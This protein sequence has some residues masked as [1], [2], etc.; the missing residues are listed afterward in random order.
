MKSGHGFQ[1]GSAS[2]L[3]LAISLASQASVAATE[4]DTAKSVAFEEV[5]VTA[6]RRT[7]RSLDVPITITALSAEQ[8]GRGDVLKLGD[9]GKLTPGLRFDDLG[10]NS[11]PTIRGVGTAV[12]V[13]GA[14][15]N[16][17]IY[18]DGF[19]SPNM[20][21]ADT[22]LLNVE[23]IQV[24]KGPQGTLFGRNSTGGAILVTTSDPSSEEEFRVRASYGSYNAER[25]EI[26]GTGGGD[27]R[28]AVDLA[29]MYRK[30]DG[31][32]ENIYTGDD[33]VGAYE[34]WMVRTGF[35]L[36][37]SDKT[38]IIL[39]H[40]QTRID[41]P[42]PVMMGFY[43]KD[44][45][46]LASAPRIA[47]E[48]FFQSVDVASE[49][50]DV[51]YGFEPSYTATSKVTQLT[52]KSDLDFANFTSY[53]QYRSESGSHAYDFDT[54]TLPILHYTFTTTDEI[55]SQEFLLS[56]TN[57]SKLQWT[58][59]LFYFS[60]ETLY[61]RN[62]AS[63]YG[64]PFAISEGSGVKASSVAVFGD[65]TYAIMDNL[66]WTIGARYSKDKSTDAY[67]YLD[68]PYRTARTKIPLDDLDDS[69]ITPRTALRFE[70]N[71][72]SSIYISYSE[73]IKSS[74]INVAAGS[75]VDTQ[76][77]L[78]VDAEEIK[79]YEIGYKYSQG[80]LMFEVATFYYDYEGLQVASYEGSDSLI[81]NAAKSS[82]Y[83][84]EGSTRY[85]FSEKLEASF[86]FAYLDAEYDDFEASQVYEQCL[87]S[88]AF[89]DGGCDYTYLWYL[90]TSTDA[91]GL[92]MQRSPEVTANLGVNYRTPLF[93]GLLNLSG[94]VYHTS[95]F[96]FDSSERFKQDPYDLI[97][98]R[99]EWTDP[100]ETYTVAI[101]GDN[102]SDEEYYSQVLPQRFGPMVT[103]A[104]PRT[105]GVSVA[106]SFK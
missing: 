104:A 86:G 93:A 51:S 64:S 101:Y 43:E 79:A 100:S 15:N 53:T 75:S 76:P 38:S 89:V 6:Q 87:N 13:A 46:A 66:F 92:D 78:E 72:H 4:N 16:V 17:A 41:D 11:Q 106:A 99:A 54:S 37:V 36:D 69:N 50:Y 84:L 31:Y 14:S 19:Y 39:R 18:T 52:I 47:S 73:G 49:P 81:N 3:A 63:F 8:L 80:S 68:P 94:S 95:S 20:L 59:G 35:K 57:E 96:Y 103:W 77:D 88:D 82:I 67:L 40:T 2:T 21:M 32:I 90:P 33:T 23:S 97:S 65:I 34:N 83:G 26:Y 42:A 9:I 10:A 7:E 30:G 70:P 12:V 102:L 22:E 74:I 105:F 45:V 29:A 61:P 91:S 48:V 56:S 28:L 5:T 27:D 44:G 98:A 60:D 85:A 62:M 1:L 25:Y 58:T 24:L 71:D 55:W